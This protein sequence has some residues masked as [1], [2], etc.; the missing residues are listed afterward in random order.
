MAPIRAHPTIHITVHAGYMITNQIVE[1]ANIVSS[2]ITSW[3]IDTGATQ[4]MSSQKYLFDNMNTNVIGTITM[5]D[6]SSQPVQGIGTI[7]LKLPR[8]P[9]FILLDV[10]Y[11]PA[12]K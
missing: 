11:I 9:D 4:H 1:M 7:K 5:A 2:I 6:R 8:L 3:I 10:L 12:L